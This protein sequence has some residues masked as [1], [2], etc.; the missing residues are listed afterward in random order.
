MWFESSVL[1]F[2][3]YTARSMKGAGDKVQG[4]QK[5]RLSKVK[6]KIHPWNFCSKE[7]NR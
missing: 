2:E 3:L 1:N 6:L 7:Q 5:S 4:E